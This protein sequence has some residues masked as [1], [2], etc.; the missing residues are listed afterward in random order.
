MII[1]FKVL[2][3]IKKLNQL[4]LYKDT[5]TFTVDDTISTIRHKNTMILG[6]FMTV[7]RFLKN[8]IQSSEIYEKVRIKLKTN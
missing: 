1:R 5:Y 4:Q 6:S 2:T 3:I 8:V 7:V